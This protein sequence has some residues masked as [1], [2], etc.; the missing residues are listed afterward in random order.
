MIN[1]NASE[2]NEVKF[3]K[4]GDALR[5]GMLYEI[6]RMI[7]HDEP[8]AGIHLYASLSY[9]YLNK[10][11]SEL[12]VSIIDDIINSGFGDNDRIKRIMNKISTILFK[13][14]MK[15][16]HFDNFES[17]VGQLNDVEISEWYFNVGRQLVK[18][19]VLNSFL[20][21]DELYYI[22]CENDEVSV[23]CKI[24]ISKLALK[25]DLD[26]T[27]AKKVLG[28]GF[29]SIYRF[30][31]RLKRVYLKIYEHKEF[32]CYYDLIEQDFVVCKNRLYT[33]LDGVPFVITKDGY[34][35]RVMGDKIDKIKEFIEDEDY[36]ERE[37][38]FFVRPKIGG[39]KFFKP[40]KLHFNGEITSADDTDYKDVLWSCIEKDF[41]DEVVQCSDFFS[42]NRKSKKAPMPRKFSINGIL[43]ALDTYIPVDLRCNDKLYILLDS[44]FEQLRPYIKDDED[45]V[46]LLYILC[47]V[48]VE[49]TDSSNV[50][51]SE[52]LYW[53]IRD[54]IDTTRNTQYSLDRIICDYNYGWLKKEMLKDKKI[55]ECIDNIHPRIGIF[56]QQDKEMITKTVECSEGLCIGNHIIPTINM[57]EYWG[58]V[59]Y[60]SNI[61]VYYVT[62][63]EKLNYLDKI[64]IEKEFNLQDKK[65]MYVQ[66]NI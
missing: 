5:Y 47:E 38:Y 43:D 44:I 16:I 4:L 31:D 29:T 27:P 25:E 46:E 66:Q 42:I 13:E 48:N 40:Y 26:E 30:D 36:C 55:K 37:D 1:Y 8:V 41:T 53:R 28:Y 15:E 3:T 50:F 49:V 21:N 6:P 23:L 34:L 2:L 9:L 61:D 12:Y 56:Y 22:S 14:L 10:Y 20:Y 7:K 18:E 59:S 54:Y 35:A 60:D 58:M 17:L 19:F 62:C 51:P 33:L 57:D 39:N 32:Y 11:I 52:E 65:M 63:K 45:I 24:H 64:Q